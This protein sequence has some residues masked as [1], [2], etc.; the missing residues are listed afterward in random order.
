MSFTVYRSSAGSGKTYTLVKEYLKIILKDTDSFRN[1]LAVTFTNKAAGEMK[2]RVLNCL[3][4]LSGPEAGTGKATRSLLPELVE[5]TGLSG[6][7]LSLKAAEVLKKILH[8]YSD[9]S[10]GTI[11]SF[12][13]RMRIISQRR[14]GQSQ[15]C[16]PGCGLSL[17]LRQTIRSV[18]SR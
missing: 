8:R 15:L 11:D 5:A 1:I 6:T 17:K 3:E 2:Q 9:F 18:G 10:I 7:E 12:S 16:M 14:L 4:E 13:R